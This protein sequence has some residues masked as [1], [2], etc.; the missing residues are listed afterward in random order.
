MKQLVVGW[1]DE[2]R[3]YPI[4]KV[5]RDDKYFSFAY[6]KGAQVAADECHF[7]PLLSFP[8]FKRIYKSA[9]MFPW[10]RHRLLSNKRPE[11]KRYL[12]W[13]QIDSNQSDEFSILAKSGGRRATD[14]FELFAIPALS[15]SGWSQIEFFLRG[16]Q[17]IST[18]SRQRIA[19]LQVNEP[20]FLMQDYAADECVLRTQDQ[21]LLGFCPK[22]LSSLLVS[23]IR[24]SP[25]EVI[26]KVQKVN[27]A[28][29]PMEFRLLCHVDLRLPNGDNPFNQEVY[30][31]LVSHVTHQRTPDKQA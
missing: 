4:G 21:F 29:T 8:D 26:A 30:K 1:Q 18:A 17:S 23:V 10:L 19:Q 20:L 28:P 9:E 22:Y 7:Q 13:L 27:Q 14:A 31:S 2:K 6:T 12:Q 11:F 3:W 15:T 24:H 16:I 25:E 5:E